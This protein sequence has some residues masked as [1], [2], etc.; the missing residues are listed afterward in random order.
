MQ[1]EFTPLWGEKKVALRQTP[2]AITPFGGVSVLIEFLQ[3]IGFGK[4][5][6]EPCGTH[7]SLLRAD[8]ALHAL[9]GMERSPTDD[10][11]RNLFKRFTQGMVVRFYEPL[12]AW[13][14]AATRG[15]R[16]EREA[17]V[18]TWTRQYLNA[19]GSRKG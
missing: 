7:A 5:V 4:Q 16:S 18:W 17:T 6:S 13:V 1:R 19:T 8:R 2:R 9:L 15:W 10:T 12:W 3:K 11:M 14:A